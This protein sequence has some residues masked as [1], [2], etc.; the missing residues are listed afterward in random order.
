MSSKYNLDP[1][2]MQ[3]LSEINQSPD[4]AVSRDI[5]KQQNHSKEKWNSLNK[6]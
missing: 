2:A 6:V 4:F 1:T 3:N 5:R